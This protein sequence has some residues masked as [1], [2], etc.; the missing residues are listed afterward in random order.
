MAAIVNVDSASGCVSYTGPKKE[1]QSIAVQMSSAIDRRSDGSSV[2]LGSQRFREQ[3]LARL[4]L[5]QSQCT[6]LLQVPMAPDKRRKAYI[7]TLGRI[8]DRL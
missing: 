6:S 5:A 2:G 1:T 3:A 8:L 7:S 4:D